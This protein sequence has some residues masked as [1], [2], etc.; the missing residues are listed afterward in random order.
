MIVD[1]SEMQLLLCASFDGEPLVMA[2][3]ET[4]LFRS[5]WL[6]ENYPRK[7]ANIDFVVSKI[8]LQKG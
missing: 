5:E 4:P 3:K 7:A 2:D 6:K 1:Q 8:N